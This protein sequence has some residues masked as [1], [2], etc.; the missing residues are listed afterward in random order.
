MTDPA[1]N[2]DPGQ[3]A[4]APTWKPGGGLNYQLLA[5]SGQARRGQFTTAHGTVQTPAFMPVGTQATVKCVLPSQVEDTGA[6]VV[7]ANTYHLGNPERRQLVKRAGGLHELMRWNQTILTD[8]GGFQVFSLSDRTI[9]E[10]GVQFSWTQGGDPIQMR[11]ED[12]MAI[13]RDLGADIVM[14]FDEC[15]G[16]PAERRYVEDSLAARLVG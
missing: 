7:L 11:P 10:D 15:V 16:Y 4:S 14:A 5:Q 3:P 1:M 8:S 13:Q 6:Q 9:D 12:S 2:D